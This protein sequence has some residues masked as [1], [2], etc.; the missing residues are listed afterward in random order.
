MMAGAGRSA[1]SWLSAYQ[2]ATV[3]RAAKWIDGAAK[4]AAP[5][6]HTHNPAGAMDKVACLDCLGI[7]EQNASEKIPIERGGEADLAAFETHEFAKPYAGQSGHERDA[8][9]D[10]L[11]AAHLL[12]DRRKLRPLRRAFVRR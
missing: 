9:G 4:E 2:I 7:V 12:G 11:D 5:H 6:R 10:L 1:G 8:I 3:E